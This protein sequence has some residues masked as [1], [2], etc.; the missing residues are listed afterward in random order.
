MNDGETIA[1]WAV[2]AALAGL[3]SEQAR[4]LVESDRYPEP[5][6]QHDRWE[7]RTESVRLTDG[8]EIIIYHT[9]TESAWLQS[10]THVVLEDMR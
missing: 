5:D 8:E 6:S 4:E 1:P 3:S 9:E 2:R 7:A 10:T